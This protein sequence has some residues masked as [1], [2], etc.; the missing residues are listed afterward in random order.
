MTL[1]ELTGQNFQIAGTIR[2]DFR[3]PDLTGGIPTDLSPSCQ[4]AQSRAPTPFPRLQPFRP[5]DVDRT[6]RE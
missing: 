5:N 6:S 4:S 1:P 2:T 3:D